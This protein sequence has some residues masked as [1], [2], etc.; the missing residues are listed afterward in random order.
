MFY[1]G[2]RIVIK[3]SSAKKKSHPN[4]GDVGYMGSAFLF[5]RERFILMDGE[6]FSYPGYTAG[7]RKSEHK[8]FII[9]LGMPHTFRKKLIFQGCTKNWFLDNAC[10]V[11]LNPV[12]SKTRPAYADHPIITH[13]WPRLHDKLRYGNGNRNDIERYT[14]KLKS[15]VRIPVGSIA[16]LNSNKYV[17]GAGGINDIKS[18]IRVMSPFVSMAYRS[19]N[20]VEYEGDFRYKLSNIYSGI[21]RYL[22][23]KRNYK[24]SEQTLFEIGDNTLQSRVKRDL[25]VRGIKEI[26]SMALMQRLRQETDI[27]KKMD[28]ESIY[29]AQNIFAGRGVKD[30]INGNI[31]CEDA[32]NLI[33]DIIASILFR[34]LI[35]SGNT[36]NKLYILKSVLPISSEEWYE[37]ISTDIDIMKEEA[38]SDSAALVRIFDGTLIS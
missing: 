9:N 32:S 34:A 4:V 22:S 36:Y 10:V 29:Y 8:Q 37:G 1:R 5:Y 6:F 16:L 21:K 15:N 28:S 7:E 33:W 18:W 12:D 24:Y 30:L 14:K 11:N 20:E 13:L 35:M 31:K 25:L 2:Q 19:V 27:F 17:V 3:S 38:K 23:L 26:Q